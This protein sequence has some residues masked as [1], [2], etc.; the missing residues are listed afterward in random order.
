M[1][2]FE[3]INRLSK[4]AAPVRLFQVLDTRLD[5]GW[6]VLMTRWASGGTSR[7][8]LLCEE[9]LCVHHV[10]SH[11]CV[12]LPSGKSTN[13]ITHSLHKYFVQLCHLL[14]R[15]LLFASAVSWPALFVCGSMPRVWHSVLLCFFFA[16][17][18]FLFLQCELFN[19][20]LASSVDLA[21]CLLMS[22]PRELG[23]Q[24][25]SGNSLNILVHS[26]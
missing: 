19:Q 22:I 26:T 14:C 6:L 15:S 20:S 23:R 13:R 12:L 4:A 25:V 17:K 1:R 5:A 10:L 9:S 7:L 21:N 8:F 3:P 18:T 2:R 11:N 16:L 24:A